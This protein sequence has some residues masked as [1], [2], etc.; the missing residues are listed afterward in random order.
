MSVSHNARVGFRR[1]SLATAT[2]IRKAV[3][4]GSDYSRWSREQSLQPSWD[5]RTQLLAS[6]IR[7]GESVLELGAGRQVLRKQIPVG[8]TYQPSDMVDRGNGTIVCDLNIRPLPDF[9]SFDVAVLSGVLE[10]LR[11]PLEVLGLLSVRCRTFVI[12]Y[13]TLEAFPD[14]IDRRS[15]G[16]ISDLSASEIVEWFEKGGFVL[17]SHHTWNGHA[18]YRFDRVDG[19]GAN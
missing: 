8:C 12:S 19:T 7:S 3:G 9:A 6:W 16:W 1:W 4:R 17:S 18:L 11:A 10:Y 13:A 14:R 2:A 5:A 15:N